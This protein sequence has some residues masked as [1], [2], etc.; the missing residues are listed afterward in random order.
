[1]LKELGAKKVIARA[2]RG[3]QEKFLL[4]NGADEVLNTVIAPAFSRK[5]NCTRD[6][7]ERE[8]KAEGDRR[9][10][11]V[12]RVK[13]IIEKAAESRAKS[14]RNRTEQKS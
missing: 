3:V 9:F 14:A 10:R 2:S 5:G 11:R 12:N 7:A 13:E 6:K 4:R 8:F 1:M